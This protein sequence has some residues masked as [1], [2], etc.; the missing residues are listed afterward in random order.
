MYTVDKST[1]EG[2][3]DQYFG[4]G[5][6]EN[7]TLINVTLEKAKKDPFNPFLKFHFKGEDGQL[8]NHTEW[9]IEDGDAKKIANFMKRIKHICTK[10][11]PEVN[12]SGSTF[13][14]FAGQVIA[15]L[16]PHFGKVKVRIKLTYSY[17][18]YVSIP[19]Y[20][21]FIESMAVAKD[22]SQLKIKSVEDGGIDKMV[23]D[24]GSNPQLS[25]TG[26]PGGTGATAGFP[27]N[28]ATDE[29]DLPF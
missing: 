18:N 2:S 26:A 13:E 20:V 1:E 24:E 25:T 15:L 22:E 9:P 8:N 4:V 5:I 11:V 12:L 3:G 23:K 16:T 7:V 17:S 6:H 10:F 29:D 27:S 14:E 19:R 28:G 21:P